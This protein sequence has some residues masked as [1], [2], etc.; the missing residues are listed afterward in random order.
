MY[1]QADE[2]PSKVICDYRL[3]KPSKTSFGWV[4]ATITVVQVHYQHSFFNF[5]PNDMTGNNTDS[6]L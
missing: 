2:S 3:I 5:K 6:K 1:V 4:S